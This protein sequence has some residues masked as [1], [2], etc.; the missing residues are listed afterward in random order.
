MSH[1]EANRAAGPLIRG[2]V[3]APL[4]RVLG[5]YHEYQGRIR[6]PSPAPVCFVFSEGDADTVTVRGDG[7]G[8]FLCIERELPTGVDMQEYG[9]AVVLDISTGTDLAPLVGQTLRDAE[10]V[11]TADERIASL[12]LRFDRSSIGFVNYD[13]ELRYEIRPVDGAA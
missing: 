13:D 5:S 9:R 11:M 2:Y 12:T 4:I 6:D 8:A 3:G 1:H 7:T 10:I